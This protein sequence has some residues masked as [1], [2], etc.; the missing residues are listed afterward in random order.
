M[1]HAN[2]LS[3]DDSHRNIQ[4][5]YPHKIKQ[6]RVPGDPEALT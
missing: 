3:V 2:H 1:F 4:L 5:Y 6:T